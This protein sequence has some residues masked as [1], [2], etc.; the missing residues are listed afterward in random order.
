M[1]MPAATS[2]T[3]PYLLAAYGLI[4]ALASLNPLAGWRDVGIAPWAFMADPWPRY[5]TQ[6]D[7]LI[8]IAAYFPFGFLCVLAMPQRWRAAPGARWLAARWLLASVAVSVFSFFMEATQTYLPLR[9]PALSD[10]VAN[11]VGGVLGA[12]AA[13]L[14][15]ALVRQHAGWQQRLTHVFAPGAGLLQA[16]VGLWMLAQLHPVS[17][18]FVTGQ[19]VPD[20]LHWVG[21]ATGHAI[22]AGMLFD[23][24]AALSAAQFALLDGMGGAVGLVSM[25]AVGRLGLQQQAPRLVMMLALLVAA[26]AAKSV[27]SM[28]QF[29]PPSAFAWLSSGA[30]S[31]VLVGVLAAVAL[32]WM[33]RAWALATGVLALML[34]LALANAIPDNPYFATTLT[35][36]HEGRF[37][38]F[39]GLTQW[40]AAAWPF[41]AMAVL[42]LKRGKF[43]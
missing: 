21:E 42:A 7:W 36:W 20:M 40:T 9:I 10:W 15:Q 14:L 19:F 5:L 26:L 6:F 28:L 38:H 43:S 13:I 30:Q 41:A 22:S 11:S 33:P 2:R 35:R 17:A 3:A 31:A 16:L 18:A 29:G 37:I 12:L 4:T 27:A 23:T 24:G 8:N 39:F 34:L 25:L 1:P 32:A